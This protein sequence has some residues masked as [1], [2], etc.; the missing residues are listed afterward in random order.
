M[1]LQQ[2]VISILACDVRAMT[3][4]DLCVLASTHGRDSDAIRELLRRGKKGAQALASTIA[5]HYE[6]GPRPKANAKG[7]ERKAGEKGNRGVSMYVHANRLAREVN[8]PFVVCRV[9]DGF[10]VKP[11]E[12]LRGRKAKPAKSA[13]S[14][15]IPSAAESFARAFRVHCGLPANADLPSMLAM[16]QTM[17]RGTIK[18][19]KRSG[20]QSVA[21]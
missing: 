20:R 5:V 9:K 19:G 1:N 10:A 12:A 17:P 3:L 4:S 7:A 18:T 11:A 14:P 8:A 15:K 13:K 2:S 6:E 16:L 21:A